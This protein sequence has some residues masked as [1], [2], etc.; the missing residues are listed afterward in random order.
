MICKILGLFF[1]ILTVDD[2]YSVLNRDILTEPFEIEISKKQKPFA[3]HFLNFLNLD[4]ILNIL[5]KK[6]TLITNLFLKLATSKE[7]IR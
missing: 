7:A 4:Q 1:N 2:N 3:N 5:Q 6:M